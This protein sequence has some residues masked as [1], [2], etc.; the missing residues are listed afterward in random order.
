MVSFGFAQDRLA[1]H[2]RMTKF[3]DSKTQ[4]FVPSMNSGQALRFS[5]GGRLIA[6][7]SIIA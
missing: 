7:P 4:P 5:K 2:E 1:H 3:Q 6:T